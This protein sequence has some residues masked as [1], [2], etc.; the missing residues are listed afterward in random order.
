[1][2]S[3]RDIVGYGGRTVGN[4]I[5]GAIAGGKGARI[6]GDFLDIRGKERH[7]SDRVGEEIGPQSAYARA[8]Q[9]KR[10]SRAG[11]KKD[12]G[13]LVEAFEQGAEDTKAFGRSQA[14]RS[15]AAALGGLGGMRGGA[16]VAGMAEAGMHA[17]LTAASQY[18][19]D[20]QRAAQARVEAR[21]AEWEMG[22]EARDAAQALAG[23]ETEIAGIISEGQGFFNDD[24]AGMLKGI[25]G[26]IN[27]VAAVNPQAAENLRQKYLV[28]GGEGYKKIHS[29]WD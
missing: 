20:K 25:E 12:Y 27:R 11:L 14:A 28:P 7:D 3:M 19:Q 1:M 29:W 6:A 15:S 16:G 10:E 24:E 22:S 13:G 2:P 23:A 5:G 17:G 21:Q 8:A 18:A 26:T 9:E 4:V